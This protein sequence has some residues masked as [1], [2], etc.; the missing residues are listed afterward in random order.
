MMF[1]LELNDVSFAEELAPPRRTERPTPRGSIR[2]TVVR[3]LSAG[4]LGASLWFS[5]GQFATGDTRAPVHVAASAAVAPSS[6]KAARKLRAKGSFAPHHLEVLPA[7]SAG[8][9]NVD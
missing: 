5:A 9:D 6:F 8:D 1:E 3:S 7:F 4:A 2:L